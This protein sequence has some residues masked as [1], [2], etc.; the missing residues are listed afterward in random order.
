MQ[1]T[2]NRRKTPVTVLAMSIGLALQIASAA[3]AQEAP[4]TNAGQSVTE[5]DRVQAPTLVLGAWASYAAFGATAD[6]VRQTFVQQ[7]ARLDGVRIE[8]SD[9]GFHFLM[10]DDPQWLRK[11]V[12]EFLQ[13]PAPT[14]H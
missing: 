8:L 10:W 4:A 12:R 11:Q 13:L 1:K 14:R 7:Y 9:T 3:N 2:N 5:L 6:S